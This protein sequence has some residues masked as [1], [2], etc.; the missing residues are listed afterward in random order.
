[1]TGRKQTETREGRNGLTTLVARHSK[2]F[3]PSGKQISAV[4]V[5][6]PRVLT[7]VY[8]VADYLEALVRELNENAPTNANAYVQGDLICMTR[9]DGKR[10]LMDLVPVQY[11]RIAGEER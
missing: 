8:N 7:I 9:S 2:L 3:D 11:Y 6:E 4:P 10:G 5:E 1:M